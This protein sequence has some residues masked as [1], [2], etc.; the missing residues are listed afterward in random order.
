MIPFEQSRCNEIL[1]ALKARHGEQFPI[2]EV[3]LEMKAMLAHTF[4]ITL[5]L[6]FPEIASPKHARLRRE[7]DRLLVI[8][9]PETFVDNHEKVKKVYEIVMRDIGDL[10]R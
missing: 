7:F 10:P 1:D 9:D 8:L 4:R 3:P 5:C 6:E 2:T